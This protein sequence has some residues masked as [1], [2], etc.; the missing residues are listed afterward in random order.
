M[1]SLPSVMWTALLR[2]VVEDTEQLRLRIDD[3]GRYEVYRRP[4]RT[5]AETWPAYR[6][7]YPLIDIALQGIVRQPARTAV[8]RPTTPLGHPRFPRAVAWELSHLPYL[9]VFAHASATL[10]PIKLTQVAAAVGRKADK[11]FRHYLVDLGLPVFGTSS[12]HCVS[13]AEVMAR[14]GSPAA[15]R[16]LLYSGQIAA[17]LGLNRRTVP[18]VV[19]RLGLWETARNGRCVVMWGD[20]RRIRRTGTS[21][22]RIIPKMG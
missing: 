19:K 12:G 22:Y 15:D 16:L 20:V 18:A 11:Q 8:N 9:D 7:L 14:L 3:E 4:G 1:G 2:V 5:A 13:L 10:I 6:D 17:F 21:T